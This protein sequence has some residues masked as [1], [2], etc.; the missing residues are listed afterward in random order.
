MTTNNHVDA[1]A[2][3]TVEEVIG[4]AIA[5]FAT[6]GYDGTK[7]ENI[8]RESGMSKRMIHDHFGD[9]RPIPAKPGNRS[10]KIAAAF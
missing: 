9:K 6:D 10:R 2:T 4:I 3:V 1:S 8:S 7:I 5:Q